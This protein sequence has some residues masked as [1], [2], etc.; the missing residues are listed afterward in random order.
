M[1]E[2]RQNE[3]IK[4]L[5]KLTQKKYRDESATFLVFGEHA[6]TEAEKSG[7]L[8]EIYTANK[9]KTG[10]LI[11]E[12]LMIELSP[13][14][15]PTE[16]LAIVKKPLEEEYSDKVLIID[17]VQDPGNLGTLIRT[18]V[19]F[20]FKTIICSFDAAD[21][22]NE[23]TISATQGT[24]F[25]ANLVKKDLVVELKRLKE[26]RYKLVSADVNKGKNIRTIAKSDKIGVILGNEGK[27]IK[28]EIKDLTD[29]FVK[30]ETSNIESL[31]VAVAGAIIM[32]EVNFR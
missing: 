16:R 25:Y 1:I 21:F 30:I 19:G 10:I 31:N 32:Y 7:N 22:Y 29:E 2:S 11:S 8:I 6:I 9:N 4:W 23:K 15:S 13:L 27:G 20:N 24:L 14:K 3:K 5:F 28:Q 17:G 18:A 12:K 26:L